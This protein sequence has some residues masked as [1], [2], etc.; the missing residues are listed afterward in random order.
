MFQNVKLTNLL[1]MFTIK[2]CN[3]TSR[4][5]LSKQRQQL[6]TAIPKSSLKTKVLVSASFRSYVRRPKSPSIIFKQ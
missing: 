6:K 5:L 2:I 1:T 4:S 3:R